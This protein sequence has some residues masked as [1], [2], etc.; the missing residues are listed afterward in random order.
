MHALGRS[1]LLRQRHPRPPFARGPDRPR[2]K[3]AAAVRTDV[4]KLALDT[5]RAERTLVSADARLRRISRKV[6][7]AILAVRPKLQRHDRLVLNEEM[8]HRKIDAPFEWRISL[9]FGRVGS[10]TSSGSCWP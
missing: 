8:D 10:L 5:V 9:E 4:T 2:G 7:V 6:L 1:R 3:A